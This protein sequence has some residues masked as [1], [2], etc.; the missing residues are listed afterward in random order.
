M[1]STLK[2]K[3]GDY[4][5]Q[6]TFDYESKAVYEAEIKK[7]K[8]KIRKLE[9]EKQT[10]QSNHNTSE[11]RLLPLYDEEMIEYLFAFDIDRENGDL[12]QENVD[13]TAINHNHE[14]LYTSILEVIKP[15]VKRQSKQTKNKYGITNPT[16]HELSAKE[17]KL[18]CDLM[19]KTIQLIYKTKRRF[20]DE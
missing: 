11:R 13:R 1:N 15:S 14:R 9:A 8:A 12:I 4:L 20:N 6:L 7:L 3:K 10:P 5:Q 2:N 18:F 17:F 16:L 19:K